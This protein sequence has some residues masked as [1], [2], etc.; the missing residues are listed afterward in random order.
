[1]PQ[2]QVKARC[3]LRRNAGVYEFQER[4]HDQHGS[5]KTERA[6]VRIHPVVLLRCQVVTVSAKSDCEYTEERN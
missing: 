5:E 4:S 6:A 2:A 1:M 3:S